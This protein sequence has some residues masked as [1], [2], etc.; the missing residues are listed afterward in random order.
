MDPLTRL[1]SAV[2]L[3]IK[4]FRLMIPLGLIPWAQYSVTDPAESTDSS[5]NYLLIV[6]SFQ[7]LLDPSRTCKTLLTP[8]DPKYISFTFYYNSL[9]PRHWWTP[10]FV[11]RKLIDHFHALIIKAKITQY[12]S[13]P[14]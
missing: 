5:L 12:K 14:L 10:N 11:A 1:Q 2:S 7:I 4:N 6:L 8:L 3:N 13:Y 9:H